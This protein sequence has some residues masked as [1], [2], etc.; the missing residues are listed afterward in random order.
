MFTAYNIHTKPGNVSSEIQSLESTVDN[1][2]NTMV[3]GDLNADCYYYNPEYEEYFP[4]WHWIIK[5]TD[6]TTVSDSSCAYDRI[7]L[8]QDMHRE[9]I[10]YGIY[11]NI[12]KDV[13]DHYPV[14]V[15]VRQW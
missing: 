2:G 4:E 13:S 10:R 8:N 6:D 1:Q 3:L 11:T 9:Y 5:D 12:T 14:W 15:E 7:L